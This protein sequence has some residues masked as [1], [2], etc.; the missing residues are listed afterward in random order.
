MKKII[1]LFSCF[2]TF[3][4]AA[5]VFADTVT[6]EAALFTEDQIE[7]LDQAVADLND[8]IK[9]EVFILTVN[10][11]D[12]DPEK[13]ADDFLR[14]Q[15]GNDNNGAVLLINMWTRDLYI[16][17]SG[18]MIDYLDDDR[19]DD[20]LDTVQEDLA[21]GDYYDGAQSFLSKSSA[22]VTE[23][24]KKGHYRIDRDTGKIIYYKVL[25]PFEAVI[26]LVL[27]AMISLIP[28][29]T[30]KAKYQ[31]KK[32]DYAYAYQENVSLKL[33]TKEDRLVN[34]FVRTRRIP[35]SPPPSSGGGGH[36]GGSTTH[37]SG[38]GTFGGGGRKF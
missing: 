10:E 33:S 13:Y 27:A 4:V 37:S 23:G 20:I 34:S 9:G 16:A 36:S 18:N 6:D 12:D 8:K 31:L 38:G 26:A 5:P 15:I 22:Y 21:N 7:S 28:F 32:A 19:L 2:L 14:E 11:D 35:K 24:V 30:V 29:F 3:F 17:T 1:L 25:T